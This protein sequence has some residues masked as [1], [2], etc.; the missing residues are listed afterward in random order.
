MVSVSLN[1]AHLPQNHV[2]F[3]P[4]PPFQF[5]REPFETCDAHSP[6]GWLPHFPTKFITSCSCC[7]L[8]QG[9]NR[10]LRQEIWKARVISPSP[11]SK[12]LMDTMRHGIFG[13]AQKPPSFVGVSCM[14][15]LGQDQPTFRPTVRIW[16][17]VCRVPSLVWFGIAK[18]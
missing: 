3:L 15:D 1:C 16:V 5:W 14:E 10:A 6:N 18:F 12:Q 4:G 2:F 9:P 11:S 7:S 8:L 13:T 17:T